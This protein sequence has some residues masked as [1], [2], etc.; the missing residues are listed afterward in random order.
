MISK[1]S[2]KLLFLLR[3]ASRIGN[4]TLRENNFKYYRGRLS[5]FY[6][7]SKLDIVENFTCA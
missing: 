2:N 6:V 3:N 1:I 5:W 4:E 7:L